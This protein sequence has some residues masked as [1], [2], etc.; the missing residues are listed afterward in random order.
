MVELQTERLILRMLRESDFDAYAE[1]LADPVVVRYI[2][3]GQPAPRQDAWR[4]M[5][6]MIGHWQLRGYGQWAVEE[7]TSGQFLGRVG[8]WNPEGWPGFE[9]GWMLRRQFWGQGFAT[10]GA[11]AALRFAFT[12]L[13]MPR[14]ISLIQPENANSIRVAERIGERLSGQVELHGKPCP[15]YAI[16]RDQW[17]AD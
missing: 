12:E 6:A 17:R 1:M 14:V 11:R 8:C 16:E 7:R 4:N 10:E 15:V 3:N 2:G 13:N 5:A 9:I